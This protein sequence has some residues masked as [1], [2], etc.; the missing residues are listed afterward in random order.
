MLRAP[1]DCCPIR[2]GGRWSFVDCAPSCNLSSHISCGVIIFTTSTL[3]IISTIT[4]T[5]CSVSRVG[6]GIFLGVLQSCCKAAL[7]Y[8]RAAM[9]GSANTTDSTTPA[10]AQQGTQK[11]AISQRLK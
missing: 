1:I 6:V 4:T 8:R 10:A 3:K 9:K 5:S 11:L 2:C 7:N